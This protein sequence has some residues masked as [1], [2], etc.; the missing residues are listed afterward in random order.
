MDQGL[1]DTRVLILKSRGFAV[2][3]ATSVDEAVKLA[4]SVHPSVG[5]ICHTLS[6][7]ERSMFANIL[8]Q[9]CPNVIIMQLRKGDVSPHHLVA[10]CELCFAPKDSVESLRGN[11]IRRF[12][13]EP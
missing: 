6:E 1:L 10:D 5:I 13:V 12:P 3:G 8:L 2:V 4:T 9:I 7:S 11:P